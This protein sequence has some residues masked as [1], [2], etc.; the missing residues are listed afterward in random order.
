[1]E[2]PAT[3]G[4]VNT[5]GLIEAVTYSAT[6]IQSPSKGSHHWIHH[7][8][9]RGECGHG[10][11]SAQAASYAERFMPSMNVDAAGNLFVVRR[12]SN[13]FT[14]KDWIIG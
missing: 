3:R 10:P 2:W 14:V 11:T 9:D 1:M 6:G 8:G 7:F 5:L 4:A 13:H 12:T